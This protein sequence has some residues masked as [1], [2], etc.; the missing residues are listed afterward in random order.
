M[1]FELIMAG[2][3]LFGLLVGRWWA[4]LAALALGVLMG[5]VIDPEEVSKFYVGTAWVVAGSVGIAVGVTARKLAG[6]A[7]RS[8]KGTVAGNP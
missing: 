6:V 4:L 7:S 2:C 1:A 8:G 3:V 5:F